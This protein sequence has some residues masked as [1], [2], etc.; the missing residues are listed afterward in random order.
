MEFFRLPRFRRAS[1]VAPIELTER[2]REI[3]RLVHRHRFLRSPQITALVCDSPQQL[4]RR[5]RLLYHLLLDR[6]ECQGEESIPSLGLEGFPPPR[7]LRLCVSKN[8]IRVHPWLKFGC[9]SPLC[10]AAPLRA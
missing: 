9:G 3:I 8:L 2:D 5:L 1:T 4:L 10:A 7:P 6:G